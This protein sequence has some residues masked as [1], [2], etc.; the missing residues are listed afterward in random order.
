MWGTSSS[1]PDWNLKIISDSKKFQNQSRNVVAVPPDVHGGQGVEG[2]QVAEVR[3]VV[4]KLIYYNYNYSF[5]TWN[6]S[7]SL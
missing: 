5:I 7:Y 4:W 2:E 6:Y 3:S 1:S